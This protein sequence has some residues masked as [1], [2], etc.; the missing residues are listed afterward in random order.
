[1]D[2]TT[3]L[4]ATAAA[5]LGAMVAGISVLGIARYDADQKAGREGKSRHLI[6]LIM[7]MGFCVLAIL[8]A[9]AE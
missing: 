9:T 1:M 6:P 4:Q 8:A 5:Y 2:A 7:G 3:F